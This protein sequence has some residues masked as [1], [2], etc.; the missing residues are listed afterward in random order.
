MNWALKVWSN[1]NPPKLPQRI[2]NVDPD[3][4]WQVGFLGFLTRLR[5]LVTVFLGKLASVSTA[6]WAQQF[7]LALAFLIVGVAALVALYWTRIQYLR[8]LRLDEKLH[9]ILHELRDEVPLVL[10]EP[11]RSENRAR[12]LNS[13]LCE[14]V[15]QLANYYRCFLADETINCA[16]RLVDEKGKEYKTCARSDGLEKSRKQRSQPIPANK[17]LAKALRDADAQGVLL[18][19]DI[20]TAIKE[21]VW[22][23]TA[24]DD[25]PDI[26]CLMVAPVNGIEQSERAMFGIIYI[27]SRREAFSAPDTLSLKAFADAL[28]MIL[29]L[30]ARAEPP[31]E[32]IQKKGN[33]QSE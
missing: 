24:T 18:I 33:K 21:Q 16:L 6:V 31:V 19:P 29:A 23:P 8:R 25:L 26:R 22:L 14:F 20:A 10:D 9:T 4:S 15:Q 11:P 27:T 12:K 30:I 28:G 1:L 3:R 2:Q 5:G 13:L 32:R 17:G 7:E